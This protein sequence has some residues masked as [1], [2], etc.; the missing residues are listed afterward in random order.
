MTAETFPILRAMSED[1]RKALKALGCPERIPLPIIATHERQAMINHNQTLRRLAERGG[2]SA[3]EAV[4]VLED[5]RWAK[6]ADEEAVSRLNSIASAW[7]AESD[8]A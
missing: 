6:M 4:C 5:R 8:H 7:H 2:L 3:C 1:R